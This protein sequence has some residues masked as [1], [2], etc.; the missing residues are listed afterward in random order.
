M[1]PQNDS[2]PRG[3]GA[4]GSGTT[5]RKGGVMDKFDGDVLYEVWRRGGNV[6]SIDFDRV[7][8]H[9]AQY[10]YD[11]DQ[12]ATMELRAQR[13]S[14]RWDNEAQDDEAF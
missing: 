8:W 7:D 1:T 12:C 3:A 11:E 6:D 14:L 13:P 2:R 10:G 4:D 9:R 5:A